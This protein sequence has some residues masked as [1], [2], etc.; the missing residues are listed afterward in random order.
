VFRGSHLADL[1]ED[2]GGFRSAETEPM[3]ADRH[4][5][6]LTGTHHSQRTTGPQ[7]HLAEPLHMFRLTIDF[8]NGARLSGCELIQR[9]DLVVSSGSLGL[10]QQALHFAKPETIGKLVGRRGV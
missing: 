6:G 8:Q 4:D 2:Q 10:G 7:S 9:H 3:I 5:A 1:D